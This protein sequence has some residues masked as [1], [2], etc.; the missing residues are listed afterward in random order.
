MVDPG[1]PDHFCHDQFSFPGQ[2][3]VFECQKRRD[4]ERRRDTRHRF[5][6]ELDG[7][8]FTVVWDSAPHPEED[9]E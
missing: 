9:D 4:H 8:E 5:E 7:R 6:D 2:Q 3:T 1:I